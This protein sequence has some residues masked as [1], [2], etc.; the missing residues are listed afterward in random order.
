MLTFALLLVDIVVFV[1][2]QQISGPLAILFLIFAVISIPA[3]VL[4]QREMATAPEI[5]SDGES[6]AHGW[7]RLF[8]DITVDVTGITAAVL[9][10]VVLALLLRGA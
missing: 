8:G 10:I 2:L 4:H 1:L 6:Q 5:A 7:L 3:L 9:V